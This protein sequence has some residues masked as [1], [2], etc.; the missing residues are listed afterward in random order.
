LEILKLN[1]IQSYLGGFFH[2]SHGIN[3]H[4]SLIFLIYKVKYHITQGTDIPISFEKSDTLLIIQ[5]P[6]RK[7]P[8]NRIMK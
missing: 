1:N 8:G 4:C 2:Y 7:T 3:V 5:P 6:K